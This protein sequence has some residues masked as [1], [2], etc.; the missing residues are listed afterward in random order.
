[1]ADTS[2]HVSRPKVDSIIEIERIL[3]SICLPIENVQIT[4]MVQPMLA[5][6]ALLYWPDHQHCLVHARVRWLEF[7]S[8]TSARRRIWT[9]NSFYPVANGWSY[10]LGWWK[11]DLLTWS[12]EIAVL[13]YT[14][15]RY[16]P[17]VASTWLLCAA[18]ISEAGAM[19]PQNKPKASK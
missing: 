15:W 2:F 7:A 6:L 11:L 1:M 17:Y 18:D 3:P 12:M 13:T 10:S 4:N 16:F 8:A 19:W 14:S 5:Y 9:C